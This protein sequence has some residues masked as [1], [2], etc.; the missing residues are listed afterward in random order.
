MP[1]TPLF[2]RLRRCLRKAVAANH[3]DLRDTAEF[4]GTQHDAALSRRQLL[5]AA[6]GLAATPVWAA[7]TKPQRSGPRIVIV[8][9]GMAGLNCAHYLQ[10]RGLKSTLYEATNRPG[11]RMFTAYDIMA[12]GLTT[13]LGGEFI[14]SIHHD[15]FALID[16]FDLSLLDSEAPSEQGLIDPGYW[17]G[18]RYYSEAEVVD[19]FRPLAKQIDADLNTLG[20]IVN[21][22]FHG[23]GEALDNTSI[24]QYLVNNGVGGVLYQLLDVAYT[25]EYG[26]AIEQQ[27]SLNLL[28]L[29][30][31]DTTNDTFA[32]FGESDERYKIAGGNSQLTDALAAS[33]PGQINYGNVLEAIRPNGSG[34]R[35]TFAGPNGTPFDVDADIAVLTI[36]FSVLRSV[37]LQ[38]PLPPFKSNAI[39]NLS[40]GTNAKLLIGF[41]SRIWRDQGFSGDLFADLPYQ[42]TWDGS[43]QQPPSQGSL[44]VF[45][46]GQSGVDVGAGTPAEQVALL[47]PG[48]ELAYP[49]VTAAQNGA[50]AR[51]HWPSFPYS[52]GSYSCWTVGQYTTIA[53]AEIVPVGN[54]FFAGEHCSY[55]YQGYM[56]GAAETGRKTAR[57][58]AQVAQ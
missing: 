50:V 41:T 44:T 49:G 39:Q 38:I 37:D 43:R 4:L 46:G 27:S 57:S 11:G 10:K 17:F 58:V 18:G 55:N 25:T 29:I 31:T 8:G 3:A 26:L 7:P 48:I 45:L 51:M 21:Y 23:H 12:P 54:L 33:L 32:L 22:R 13:E 6:A 36:P 2:S 15:M 40:Y 34:F 16:E 56:N 9:A 30:G 28:F 52:K 19:M 24:A 47:L 35:L 53:G 5:G 20:P 14:D 1:R 42:T